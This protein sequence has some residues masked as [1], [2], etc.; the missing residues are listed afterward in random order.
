M[1]EII[2]YAETHKSINFSFNFKNA[3]DNEKKVP[4]IKI[5]RVS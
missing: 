2:I 3:A 5:K 1:F 4:T